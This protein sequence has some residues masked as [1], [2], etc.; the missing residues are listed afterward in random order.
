MNRKL[1]PL[2]VGMVALPAKWTLPLTAEQDI[3]PRHRN[4]TRVVRKT[5]T[6]F[7]GIRMERS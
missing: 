5:G 7:R 6:Q 4:Y 2:L 1:F 3:R